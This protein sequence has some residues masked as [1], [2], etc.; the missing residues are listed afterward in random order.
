MMKSKQMIL[1]VALP[2]NFGAHPAAWR[3]PHIDPQTYS[4]LSV[5][6]EH[7]QAAE[8]GGFDFVFMPDR[9]YMHGDVAVT[10]PVFNIDTIISLAAVVHATTRI[11]LVTTAS[12]SFTEPYLLAR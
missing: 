10:P 5:T 4:D 7:V 11:G 9:L 8:R 3:M 6:I 12:T 1:G 2:N